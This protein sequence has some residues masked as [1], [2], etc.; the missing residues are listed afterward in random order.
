MLLIMCEKNKKILNVMIKKNISMLDTT[1]S[2]VIKKFPKVI[3]FEN[4]RAYFKLQ[5]KKL[6]G[7]R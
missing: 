2:I 3:N 4:K 7:E 6:R 5:I 1:L